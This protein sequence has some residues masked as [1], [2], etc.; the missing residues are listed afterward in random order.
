MASDGKSAYERLKK[1]S[2]R[3]ELLPVGVAVM[4]GAAGKVPG[5]VMTERWHL[6]TWLVNVSTQKTTLLHARET[7]CDPITSSEIDVRRDD[8]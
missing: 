8:V 3:G 2:H 4:F 6:G 5:G 1:R 7:A